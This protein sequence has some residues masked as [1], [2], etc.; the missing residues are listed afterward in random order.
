MS[1]SDFP[2]IQTAKTFKLDAETQ[3]EVVTSDNDRTSP[4]S[5]GKTKLTLK[6]FENQV[7]TIIAEGSQEITDAIENT[8]GKSYI[9]AWTQGVTTFTTMNEYS[10]FNGITYKPKSGVT[11]PYTAQTADPTTAPDNANVEPFSDVNSSNIQSLSKV[12][13]ENVTALV[14]SSLQVG[15]VVETPHYQSTGDGGGATYAV[16]SPGSYTGTPDELGDHTLVNGNIA[17]IIDKVVCS[18]QFG[19]VDGQESGESIQAM[20]NWCAKDGNTKTCVIGYNSEQFHISKSLILSHR[21]NGMNIDA[22]N[23]WLFVTQGTTSTNAMRIM[24]GKYA[25]SFVYFEGDDLGVPIRDIKIGTLNFMSDAPVADKI[26][27]YLDVASLLPENGGTQP[28]ATTAL[29]NYTD[30]FLNNGY[31][32]GG[33]SCLYSPSVDA[34]NDVDISVDYMSGVDLGNQNYVNLPRSG[35]SVNVQTLDTKIG[36]IKHNGSYYHPLSTSIADAFKDL[37]DFKINLDIDS[38]MVENCAT[39]FDFSAITKGNAIPHGVIK[40][41][42]C[43]G[44]DIRGRTKVHGMYDAIN[45]SKFHSTHRMGGKELKPYASLNFLESHKLVIDEMRVNGVGYQ[46]ANGCLYVGDQAY[47]RDISIGSIHCQ[48]TTDVVSDEHQSIIYDQT[49]IANGV[50]NTL[51]VGDVVYFGQTP[52]GYGM[53]GTNTT[54]SIKI[55]TAGF[56]QSTPSTGM[57]DAPTVSGYYGH[58]MID[59]TEFTSGVHP[60]FTTALTNDTRQLS[61]GSIHLPNMTATDSGIIVASSFSGIDVSI[62]SIII[63]PVGSL[64]AVCRSAS[65]DGSRCA[66]LS[67]GDYIMNEGLRFPIESPEYW[68]STKMQFITGQS[69]PKLTWWDSQNS[70][71]R[72]NSDRPTD[73]TDGAAF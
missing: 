47:K 9:G 17:V 55:F 10:D 67:I 16:V 29:A 21:H 66:I 52:G 43:D 70:T 34:V 2:T 3:N 33:L 68:I 6:G 46:N 11:L 71:L 38:V 15:S 59:I 50:N 7:D 36:T 32:T 65:S 45:I 73:E 64:R 37:A 40:I 56:Q 24:M 14:A 8:I 19:A 28:D 4:A 27:E 13:L 69:R 22:G 53:I 5:D 61:I 31:G 57:L 30:W 49:T 26:A 35:T 48:G 63:N 12:K 62:G 23:A 42:V 44:K 39:I 1:C 58:I 41:G 20:F 60:I 25:T 72:W 51:T 54:S 18:A